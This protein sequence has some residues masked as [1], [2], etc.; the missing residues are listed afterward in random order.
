LLLLVLPGVVGIAYG[1]LSITRKEAKSWVAAIGILLN[2][3]F[4]LFQLFV[5]SFAG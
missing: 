5:I 1:I 4:T 2:A 3:L